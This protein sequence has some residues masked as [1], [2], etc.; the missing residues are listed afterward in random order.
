MRLPW[1]I[2]VSGAA[3]TLV[4]AHLLGNTVDGGFQPSGGGLYAD[5]ADVVIER[6]RPGV[7]DR[8]W[9]DGQQVHSAPDGDRSR[10]DR[11]ADGRAA[12]DDDAAD[13]VGDAHQRRVKRGRDVPDDV[14]A[15]EHG[16]NEHGGVD[17]DGIDRTGHA[18]EASLVRTGAPSMQTRVALMMSSAR[19][20]RRS[21][22]AASRSAAK[23]S[24]PTS[25]LTR[26]SSA[27]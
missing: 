24:Q 3:L 1:R 18:S 14:V 5:R 13:R 10:G 25:S 17:D 16:E 8:L 23:P 15:D 4:N 11:P 9:F 12:D 27:G 7:V 22:A 20:A 2:S 21:P 26:A 19:S 6:F